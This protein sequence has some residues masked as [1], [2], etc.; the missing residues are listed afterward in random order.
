MELQNEVS[1]G[2]IVVHLKFLNYSQQLLFGV[3]GETPTMS[4]I[5]LDYPNNIYV[6]N[7]VWQLF[8]I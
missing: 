1:Q 5:T 6:T 7:R 8:V 2:R 3:E 4:T